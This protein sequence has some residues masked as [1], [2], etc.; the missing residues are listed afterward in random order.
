MSTETGQYC[1]GFGYLIDAVSNQAAAVQQGS[2]LI[3][4]KNPLTP[5]APEARRGHA[6]KELGVWQGQSPWLGH[7]A[8]DIKCKE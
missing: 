3:N 6:Q 1:L 8:M 7:T 2:G 5:F 4:N